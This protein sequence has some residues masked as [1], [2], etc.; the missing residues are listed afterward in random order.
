[1]AMI[2]IAKSSIRFKQ[3]YHNSLIAKSGVGMERLTWL[4]LTKERE[5]G[6]PII[7]EV[8]CL[9]HEFVLK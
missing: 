1:M 4:P 5:G 6:I 9:Y 8:S 3:G 2:R 7:N